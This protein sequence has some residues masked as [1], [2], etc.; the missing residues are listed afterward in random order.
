MLSRGRNL[1]NYYFLRDYSL[2]CLFSI[3]I[4]MII[5]KYETL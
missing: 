5:D 3:F 4:Q 1:R 2:N